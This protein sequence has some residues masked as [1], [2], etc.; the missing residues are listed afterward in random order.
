MKTLSVLVA[1]LTTAS[2]SGTIVDQSVPHPPALRLSFGPFT[3]PEFG[4]M[5]GASLQIY[6][7][8][9]TSTGK[10]VTP[11]APPTFVS[12]NPTIISST[13]DGYLTALAAGSSLLVAEARV[14]SQVVR[15]SVLGSVFCTLELRISLSPAQATLPIGGR[16]VPQVSLSTCGGQVA[17]QDTFTWASTDSS[18]LSVDSITGE[19]IALSPGRATVTATAARYGVVG[20]MVVTVQ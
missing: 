9:V 3:G 15:D 13:P 19:T 1:A 14:G 2:C 7:H 20:F 6:A 16:L 18:I 10:T 4:I 12:R 5:L 17:V 8:V 11:D